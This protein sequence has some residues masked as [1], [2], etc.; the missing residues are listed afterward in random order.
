M[1]CLPAGDVTASAGLP[2]QAATVSPISASLWGESRK[3]ISAPSATKVFSRVS[4]SS[5]PRGGGGGAGEQQ[6]ALLAAC[7][8]GGAAAQNGSVALDYQFGA[9]MA[10]RARPGFVLE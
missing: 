2:L 6:N 4:A 5:P 7:L 3:R 1:K 8:G 10:E 9:V